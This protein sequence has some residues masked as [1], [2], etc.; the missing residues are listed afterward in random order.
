MSEDIREGD[1]KCSSCQTNNFSNRLNCF[2]C[3]KGRQQGGGA[4]QR[5]AQPSQQHPAPLQHALQQEPGDWRC[6]C[7]EINFKRRA[8]CRQC[9]RGRT[10]HNAGSQ[11]PQ[12]SV[13][14]L[15]TFMILVTLHQVTPPNNPK[16][17][18]SQFRVEADDWRCGCGE[19]NFTR[20]T[21]C[22]RCGRGRAM[23]NSQSSAPLQ[24]PTAQQRPSRVPAGGAAGRGSPWTC[25]CRAANAGKRQTC[26]SCGKPRP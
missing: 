10:N 4:Q 3:G 14:T 21:Q 20:R 19:V 22:R 16:Q 5:P 12:P 8:N 7:G 24:H 2:G 18:Q 25:S 15:V 26:G 6:N 23:V 9:G 11:P 17:V 1:W 13:M